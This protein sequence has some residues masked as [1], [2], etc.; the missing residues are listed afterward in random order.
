MPPLRPGRAGEYRLR[1]W[2]KD[3]GGCH[4]AAVPY[5]PTYRVFTLLSPYRANIFRSWEFDE[6]GRDGVHGKFC[7]RLLHGDGFSQTYQARLLRA[8]SLAC[9]ALSGLA[10]GRRNL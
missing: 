4:V 1:R 2:L 8:T 10:D 9:P 5:G 7:S 3:D 6:A